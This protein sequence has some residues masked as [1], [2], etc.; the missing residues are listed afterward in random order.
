MRKRA[1]TL[2]ARARSGG[3]IFTIFLQFR[4]IFLRYIAAKGKYRGRSMRGENRI[5]HTRPVRGVGPK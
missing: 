5:D 4:A 2:L 3:Q 1:I